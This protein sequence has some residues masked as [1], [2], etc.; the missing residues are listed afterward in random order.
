MDRRNVAVESFPMAARNKKQ[1]RLIAA[2]KYVLI[3]N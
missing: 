3:A 2:G 1:K